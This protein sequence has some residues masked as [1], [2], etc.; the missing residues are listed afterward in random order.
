[1]L[2]KTN[3]NWGISSNKCFDDNQHWSENV[4][5]YCLRQLIKFTSS[6]IGL[7]FE[8]LENQC[9]DNNEDNG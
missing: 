6:K 2:I 8:F 9:F 3:S 7:Y 5:K 4:F 1:M